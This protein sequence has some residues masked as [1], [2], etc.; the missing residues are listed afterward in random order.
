MK[1][2]K[3]RGGE[4]RWRPLFKL[5]RA[6]KRGKGKRGRGGGG[7]V[8]GGSNSSPTRMKANSSLWCRWEKR[9]K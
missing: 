1:E 4:K 3:R 9:K 6:T 7:G 5:L 2:K 8:D